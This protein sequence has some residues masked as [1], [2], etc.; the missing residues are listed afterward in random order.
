METVDLY[1]SIWAA[2][3]ACIAS[4]VTTMQSPESLLGI[5]DCHDKTLITFL[6]VGHLHHFYA[7]LPSLCVDY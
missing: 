1:V 2:P 4:K 3:Y 6:H 7:N 5:I